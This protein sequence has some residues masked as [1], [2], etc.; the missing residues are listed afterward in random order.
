[1]GA[2]VLGLVLGQ[3]VLGLV[4]AVGGVEA[5]DGV[6]LLH[7]AD[8]ADGHH[9]LDGAARKGGAERAKGVSGAWFAA[10]GHMGLGG[11]ERTA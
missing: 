9:E 3:R 11:V 5:A 8:G 4:L 6:V 1:M 10:V 2:A 7:V